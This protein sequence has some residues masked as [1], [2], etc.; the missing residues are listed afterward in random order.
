MIAAINLTSILKHSILNNSKSIV[1]LLAGQAVSLFFLLLLVWLEQA[2]QQSL[3]TLCCHYCLR[4]SRG[5]FSDNK[6]YVI[7]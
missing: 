2:G 3:L 4:Q 5:T 6:L 7:L 1:W